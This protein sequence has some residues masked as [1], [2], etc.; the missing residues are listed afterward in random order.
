MNRSAAR[1]LEIPRRG[2]AD[3]P[4]PN[5]QAEEGKSART[6]RRAEAAQAR[7]RNEGEPANDNRVDTPAAARQWANENRQESPRHAR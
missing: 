2:I 5:R 6:R 1:R 4:G 7:T 3:N